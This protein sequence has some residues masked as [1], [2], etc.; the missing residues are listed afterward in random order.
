MLH[1]C[2][3]ATVTLSYSEP[4]SLFQSNPFQMTPFTATDSNPLHFVIQEK[5]FQLLVNYVTYVTL[6]PPSYPGTSLSSSYIDVS[7]KLPLDLLMQLKENHRAP[8][9]PGA[10]TPLKDWAFLLF[11]AAPNF[12]LSLFKEQ[13]QALGPL[14]PQRGYSPVGEGHT[15]HSMHKGPAG[16]KK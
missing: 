8:L 7:P 3:H 10:T 5:L 4:V 9:W 1:D 2:L 6:K 13:Q 11:R 14:G 16:G 15:S 12:S